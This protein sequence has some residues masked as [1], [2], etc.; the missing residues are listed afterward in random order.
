M[1]DRYAAVQSRTFA[2]ERKGERTKQKVRPWGHSDDLKALTGK[3]IV[4]KFLAGNEV[5]GTLVAHDAYT[6]KLALNSVTNV[7]FKSSL[8][9]FWAA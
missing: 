2:V 8:V 7:Y 1:Q 3:E 6:I 4:L 5:K 9:G